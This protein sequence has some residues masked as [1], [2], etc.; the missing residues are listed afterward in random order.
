MKDDSLKILAFLSNGNPR[1]F[2]EN[3]NLV[4]MLSKGLISAEDVLNQLGA[5]LDE[6]SMINLAIVQV[7]AKAGRDWIPVVNI[8]DEI[9]HI[10]LKDISSE[11]IGRYLRRRLQLEHRRV[12]K[13]EEYH[14]DSRVAL[15]LLPVTF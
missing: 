5:L 12:G 3:V 15:K 7:K 10:F 14:L 4:L 11:K 6:E 1:K 2:I 13:G 9:Y 8:R